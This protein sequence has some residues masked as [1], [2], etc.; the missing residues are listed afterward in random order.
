MQLVKWNEC[1]RE[2]AE[3]SP[4]AIRQRATVI[5]SFVFHFLIPSR[6]TT[7]APQFHNHGTK[8]DTNR[9]ITGS[10]AAPLAKLANRIDSV[11]YPNRALDSSKANLFELSIP[12][13]KH[14]WDG[15]RQENWYLSLCAVHPDYQGKG[16][17]RELVEWGLKQAESENV[18]ASVMSS[19]GSD[20]FYLRC[21]FEEIVGNATDGEGNPLTGIKGG[22]ILFKHPKRT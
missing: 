22:S 20:G 21:G 13:W 2:R 1:P 4:S 11:L 5:T 14:H 12:Y 7:S 10:L 18:H 8:H 9:F 19:N 15:E 16:F 17:G 6:N 3:L